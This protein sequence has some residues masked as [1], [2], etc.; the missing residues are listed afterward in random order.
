MTQHDHV[1]SKFTPENRQRY[2]RGVVKRQ[3]KF[4]GV[5]LKAVCVDVGMI[6]LREGA[7]KLTHEHFTSG[8]SEG[9][10]VILLTRSTYADCLILQSDK[11]D[12]MY[13]V[14]THIL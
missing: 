3:N 2:L 7:A 8:I 14:L 12:L 10:S 4:N 1:S 6:V 5:Q 11:N 9:L 13:F